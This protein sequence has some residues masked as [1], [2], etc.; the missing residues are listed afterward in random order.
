MSLPPP[1]INNTTPGGPHVIGI[2]P[3]IKYSF[4][5]EQTIVQRSFRSKGNIQNL[6]SSVVLTSR[7]ER[8]ISVMFYL[9][10]GMSTG[11][12]HQG[13]LSGSLLWLGWPGIML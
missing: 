5:R 12:K 10:M 11:I 1:Q 9:K 7:L 4:S 2:F 13:F 3:Q 8:M 6:A